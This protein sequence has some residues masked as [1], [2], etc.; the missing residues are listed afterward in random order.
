VGMVRPHEGVRDDVA[1]VVLGCKLLCGKTHLLQQG[2]SLWAAQVSTEGSPASEVAEIWVVAKVP[3]AWA[4]G[5]LCFSHRRLLQALSDDWLPP[6]QLTAVS[7]TNCCLTCDMLSSLGRPPG[8][9]EADAA[10]D[11][12]P[13]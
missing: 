7:L 5:H 6:L 12:I 2:C 13:G 4:G 1:N 9:P 3:A 11:A 10:S 8:R